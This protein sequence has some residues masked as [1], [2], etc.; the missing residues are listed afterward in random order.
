MTHLSTYVSVI[1]F[2]ATSSTMLIANKM[3]VHFLPSASFILFL[4][5]CFTAVMIAFLS[6]IGLVELSFA[7]RDA[8]R[9][10]PVAVGIL[11]CMYFNMRVLEH[12]NVET[13]IVFRSTTPFV[14]G[15]LEW[16]LL[17]RLFPK[18]QSLVA[19]FVVTCGCVAYA[20]LDA[21]FRVDAYL[22]VAGWYAVFCFDQ[23]YIKHAV[24]T[25]EIE[26]WTR[27]FLANGWAALLLVPLV[28]I[29]P[30]S[31]KRLHVMEVQ[32]SLVVSCLIGFAISYFAFACRSQVSATTF[33]VVGN[34]C[35]LLTILLN[36][37]IWEHHAS[38]EGIAALCVCLLASFAY[39][40]APKRSAVAESEFAPLAQRLASL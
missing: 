15:T 10:F 29:N 24:D 31:A 28:A 2:A 14:I 19:M 39:K 17:D 11:S 20:M 6:C 27:V 16:L 7:K 32:I 18:A 4:Q 9:F 8:M 5:V 13:F 37:L 1:G 40:E 30:P 23:L 26:N 22:W 38:V 25:S 3:T 35:K 34:A 21:S 12:S 33:S 36:Y